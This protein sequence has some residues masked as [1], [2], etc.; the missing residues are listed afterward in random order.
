M[1]VE[2]VIQM[3]LTRPLA[4]K[5]L[6][7]IASDSSRVAITTHAESRM[8]RRRITRTQIERCL[9]KGHIT[10]GP[11]RGTKGNW[12]MR[13][14]VFSAGEPVAVVAALDYDNKGNYIIVITVF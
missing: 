8:K 2:N 3:N 9:Q 11:A 1:A 4:M 7:E 6:R 12:E 14:E 13:V 5:L 10:E